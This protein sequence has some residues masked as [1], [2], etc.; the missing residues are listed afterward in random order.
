VWRAVSAAWFAQ[1]GGGVRYRATH[2]AQ[3]LVALGHLAD[4][5]REDT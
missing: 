5:T 2:S 3:E 4:I 1:P